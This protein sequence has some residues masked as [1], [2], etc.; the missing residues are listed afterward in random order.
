MDIVAQVIRIANGF[1]VVDYNS[2]EQHYI[3]HFNLEALL[4]AAATPTEADHE[5]KLRRMVLNFPR[6][7]G[8]IPA[9][10]AVRQYCSDNKWDKYYGL[11]DAKDY[12][13][14]L[15]DSEFW[16]GYPLESD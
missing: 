15:R 6:A 16:R 5:L 11:K 3:S 13:E 14:A 10:K 4:L 1:L 9:I 12:V 7:F 2:G 8:K